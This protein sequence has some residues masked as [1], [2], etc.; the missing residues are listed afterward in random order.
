ML[1]IQSSYMMTALSHHHLQIQT[2]TSHQPHSMI[3]KLLVSKHGLRM[4]QLQCHSVRH[5]DANL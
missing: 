4:I 3:R 1:T 5:S 2:N